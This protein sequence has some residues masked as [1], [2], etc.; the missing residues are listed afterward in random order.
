MNKDKPKK[1]NFKATI[2]S[3]KITQ[4]LIGR[5]YLIKHSSYMNDDLIIELAGYLDGKTFSADSMTNGIEYF[6]ADIE[7]GPSKKTYRLIWL[8]D[9]ENL[10]I[11]GIVNAYRRRK[12]QKG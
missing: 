8:F 6:V 1:Y 12:S 4:I 9:G 5:H 10:E 2:N 11:L 3:H 7:Y